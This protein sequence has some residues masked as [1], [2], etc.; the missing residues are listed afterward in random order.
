[1]PLIPGDGGPTAALQFF[2]PATAPSMGEVARRASAEMSAV[3]HAVAIPAPVR[4]SWSGE[5]GAAAEPADSGHGVYLVL[6]SYAG[7]DQARRAAA[8]FGDLAAQVREATVGGQA[9]Y[10]VV[11]GPYGKTE[12]QA[13][14]D[15]MAGRGVKDAWITRL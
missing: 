7:R 13:R 4:E 14:R 2:A 9:R 1:M 15:S 11:A 3:A 10:R 5:T 8:G 12:A 6:G